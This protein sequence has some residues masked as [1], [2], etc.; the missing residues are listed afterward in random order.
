V[1]LPIYRS[2]EERSTVLEYCSTLKKELEEQTYGDR[3]IEII[4]DDRD[5]RDKKWQQIKRGVPLRLEVGPKEVA[6]DSVSL[7]RRD[8]APKDK[9]GVART[10]LVATIGSILDEIQVG[11]FQ[12]ALAFRDEHTHEIDA[13]DDFCEFFKSG[14]EKK[15]EGGFAISPWTE[16]P[17]VAETLK[18]MKVTTRCIPEG[19]DPIDGKCI[20][21]DKPTTKRAV[22]AKA[23]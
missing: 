8:K 7:G 9:R 21:T 13:L 19:Q 17:K 23:Y 1:I 6:S 22:F 16:D 5:L 4:V 11:L 12:R 20:F 18:D 14:G 15:I 10:E 3:K 2:D